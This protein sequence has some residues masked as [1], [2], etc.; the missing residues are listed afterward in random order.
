M[1]MNVKYDPADLM[2][3]YFKAMQDEQSILVSL[4]ETDAYRFL[5][6]LGL[7]QFNSPEQHMPVDMPTTTN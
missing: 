4:Q 6:L 7:Y 1:K 2:Q 5:I 3:V